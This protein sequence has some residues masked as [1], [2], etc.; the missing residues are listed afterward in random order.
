MCSINDVNSSIISE[1]LSDPLNFYDRDW[2]R[3]RIYSGKYPRSYF[4]Y[5]RERDYLAQHYI[6]EDQTW[7][8]ELS[9]L[10]FDFTSGPDKEDNPEA[11]DMEF[12]AT[13]SDNE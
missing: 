13:I 6:E 8:D 2:T 9:N 7:L 1:V 10:E 3:A 11:S 12:S 4:T 5:L